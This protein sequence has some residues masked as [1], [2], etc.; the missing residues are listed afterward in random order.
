MDRSMT[1]GSMP[2]A[3]SE[4]RVDVLRGQQGFKPGIKLFG[5]GAADLFIV[6]QSQFT[7]FQSR[8]T[9]KC[10]PCLS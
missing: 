5:R 10:R 8:Q 6:L 1:A 7:K 3:L 9:Q 2:G 4:H